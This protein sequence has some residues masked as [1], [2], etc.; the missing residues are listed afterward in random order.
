MS[1]NQTTGAT[2][3]TGG[4]DEAG[5]RNGVNPWRIGVLGVVIVVG[6]ATWAIALIRA[7]VPSDAAADPPLNMVWGFPFW[8]LFAVVVVVYVVGFF[9]FAYCMA[10]RYEANPPLGGDS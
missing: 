10:R 5:Q 3:T 4:V 6:V 7:A 1:E 2:K 8:Q 9:I